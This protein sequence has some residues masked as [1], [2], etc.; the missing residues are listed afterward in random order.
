MKI[1]SWHLLKSKEAELQA[2]S[3]TPPWAP[4]PVPLAGTESRREA[5]LR[6]A[7]G[8]ELP[9]EAC[10]VRGCP[11]YWQRQ[12]LI[13]SLCPRGHEDKRTALGPFPSCIR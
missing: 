2:S 10:D 4:P 5:W 11:L 3:S 13:H 6:S 8:A 7:S 1:I 9:G 12:E